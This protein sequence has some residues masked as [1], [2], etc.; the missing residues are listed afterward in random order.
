M[1]KVESKTGPAYFLSIILKDGHQFHYRRTLVFCLD[2]RQRQEGKL[3]QVDGEQDLQCD[4]M[5]HINTIWC[6][7][8]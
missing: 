6:G 8:D 5:M 4:L 3:E 7:M 1:T 2:D